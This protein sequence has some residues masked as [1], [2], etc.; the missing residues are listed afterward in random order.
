MRQKIFI[1]F[2][3]LLAVFFLSTVAMARSD[4]THRGPNGSIGSNG[5]YI[6]YVF[7]DGTWRE[8]NDLGFNRFFRQRIIDLGSYLSAGDPV[9]IRLVHQGG[10]GA[11][12]DAVLLGGVP[13]AHVSGIEDE[14][15]LKKISSR[16]FDVIDAFEKEIELY[17]PA[18]RSDTTLSI[19]ARVEANSISKIPFQFPIKNLFTSITENSS[20]Y[21]YTLNSEKNS[22]VDKNEPF[23]KEYCLAGSGHPSGYTYGWVSNDEDNLYVRID[24]T[25][26]NTMDGEK[27]YAKVYIKTEAGIREFK[28]SVPETRWGE[29]DFTYT[30]KV[31]YQH[32]VY[33]FKI[34]L[35]ELEIINAHKGKELRLAFAAYGTAAPLSPWNQANV[36]GFG[37]P[38]EQSAYRMAVYNSKLYVGIWGTNGAQVYKYD[39]STWTKI[40][41]GWNTSNNVGVTSMA[42][43]MGSLFVGT[44]NTNSGAEVWEYDGTTWTNITTT[45]PWTSPNYAADSM[46]EFNNK[47]YV[48]TANGSGSEVWE[49]DGSNWSQVTT[50]WN[51]TNV[52]SHR[53]VVYSS[54]LYV[55]T[56]NTTTG[57]E[58]W[59]YDGTWANITAT[60]PWGSS[61]TAAAGMAEFNGKLYV[62]TYNA[63]TGA[64]VWE[65]ESSWSQVSS[66]GFGDMNNQKAN[67]MA[68]YNSEL[69]VGTRNDTVGA[70]IW[71]KDGTFYVDTTLGTDLPTYGRSPGAGAWKTLHFAID[72]INNGSTG[73][74]ILNVAA[75]TY[76]ILNEADASLT[77]SQSNVTVQGAGSG[78][79]IFDGSST[80]FWDTGIEIAASNEFQLLRDKTLLRLWK[81]HP[82]M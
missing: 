64:E 2:T 47:L 58:V 63:S 22:F 81:H 68:V 60:S 6:V 54:K 15:A 51:A 71:V 40:T 17:F 34:P 56:E 76:D 4:A 26:D 75:G 55:G 38:N 20:F 44:Y 9:R 77:I 69:Y 82:G 11:H 14:L 42:E 48:A 39:G 70:Q 41:P 46:A 37:T 62:A 73:T 65:Y 24:F 59:E 74:Y 23:F 49:Y 32:K 19:T 45:L 5:K 61:T 57:A 3:G 12:I 36:S 8:A 78:S 13:P 10:G 18:G 30:P 27:D 28:V 80:E 1:L 33:D 29:P 31:P 72:Q 35:E 79:T 52:R 66:W 25:P 43:Y 16:D 53:M 50:S 7:Q 21:T 67:G